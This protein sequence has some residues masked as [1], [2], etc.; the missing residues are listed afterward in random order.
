MGTKISFW[1]YLLWELE[2][3][4]EAAITC[5]PPHSI[6]NT[7]AL[8]GHGITHIAFRPLQIAVT[9]HT[10]SG[11]EIESLTTD[12]TPESHGRGYTL[13]LGGHGV[14]HN[15][16]GVC[17]R[18]ET[19]A[20]RAAIKVGRCQI[21]EAIKT[22]VASPPLH[23]WLAVTLATDHVTSIVPADCPSSV[24]ATGKTTGRHIIKSTFTRITVLASHVLS[25]G[26]LSCN[27]MTN[28]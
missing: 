16:R 2:E 17:V 13:T 21:C 28:V 8:P 14:A 12:I 23:V 4:R 19:V 22:R 20:W 25:A 7:R 5:S 9:C 3:P 11:G 10:S 6:T 24:T 1:L 18:D 15:P 26:T 27:R